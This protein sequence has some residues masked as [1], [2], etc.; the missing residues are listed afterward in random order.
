MLIIR[1]V[2]KDELNRFVSVGNPQKTDRLKRTIRNLLDNGETS[3]H[4]LFAAEKDGEFIARVL[5]FAPLGNPNDL[6]TFAL[7][8]PWDDADYLET[9]VKL[10]K[11]SLSQLRAKG[12]AQVEHRVDSDFKRLKE[13]KA[14]MKEA[15]IP[16][17]QE[18]F[19]MV[20]NK[21][22]T[23][24]V[25]E[26]LKFRSISE[27]G[28][29]EFIEAIERVTRETLD[30]VDLLSIEKYGARQAALNYFNGLKHIDFRPEMWFLAYD[31][32]GRGIGLVIAQQFDDETGA[33]NYIGV[34]PEQRGH[35]YV[36]DLIA[37]AT[38]ALKETGVNLIIADIDKTNFPLENALTKAGY[39]KE[40]EFLVYVGYLGGILRESVVM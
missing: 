5:Y 24:E 18:K 37:K 31:K 26:R 20:Y 25:P 11:Q 35:G 40:S 3:F 8:V 10:I 28:E 16:L 9:G 32:D 22:A 36:K 6:S 15:G 19:S 1:S 12:I 2:R 14:L 21:D 38:A 13:T 17:I 7:S 39:V 4:H 27:T 23:P 34:F 30:K 29:E 33:I